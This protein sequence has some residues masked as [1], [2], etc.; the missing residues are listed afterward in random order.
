MAVPDVLIGLTVSHYRI[1]ERLASGG[2]GVVYKAQDTRLDRT[3][4]LKFLPEH[5][6]HDA[7]ALERFRREAKAASALNHPNICTV[8]DIGEAQIQGHGEARQFMAMEFLDGETLKHR[9]AG[10]PLPLELL[11][12]LGIEMADALDAAHS[13]GIIHRDIKPANIFVTNREHAKIL[14]FGL[15][16]LVPSGVERSVSA[17]PTATQ[18]EPM[19]QLGA[20]MGT[21]TYMSP[22]QVRGEE[23]DARTDLFSFGAVL[24]EMA[25]GT[26]AF[27]G[28]TS[29]VIANAIL[30]RVPMPPVQLNPEVPAK[31]EEVIT[32]ALEKDLKLR[33]QH[34]ADVRADLERLKRN[35]E[36]GRAVLGRKAARKPAWPRALSPRSIWVASL[37][38]AL[39]VA[40]VAVLLVKNRHP[41]EAGKAPGGA[42][43]IR[44]MAVLP[45]A[46]LS[47]DTSQDFFAD[48]ITAELINE[49]GTI[50]QLR[51]VS[52][53]S[54]MGY[55]GT[56]TP[57]TQ[58]AR[59]LNVDAILEGSVARSGNHVRIGVGLYDGASE[60]EVWSRTFER[61]MNDVLALED[62]V[63]HA[64]AVQIRLKIASS[65]GARPKVD[66]EA[67]DLYLKGRYAL[68]QGSEDD[69][70]LALVYFHKGIEKDPQYA[71]LY[72]EL[73]NAYALRSFYTDTRPSD[74]FPEAK[75]AAT[76]AL[77]LDPGLAEGHA[78]LA[79]ILNYYDWDRSGAEQEFERALDLNAN[80]AA[81]HQMYARFLASMG[82]LDEA[83]AEMDRARELDPLSLIIQSNAG[84]IA[85]FARQYDDALQQLQKV[86]E[87]DP[88]F[89]VPYWGM[90]LC[91]EQ[92]TKYP[93]AIAQ[94]E[95]GIEL[96]GRGANGIASLAHAYGLAGHEAPARRILAELED[97]S[98]KTYVSSYQFAVI[99]LGLG[100]NQRAMDALENAYRERSTLLG[101]VKMDPRFD[102]L[103]SDP[104]FQSLLSRIHLAK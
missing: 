92:Q 4:A 30:E 27:Q 40:A 34:A 77:Q 23:L 58:I 104:R 19:T 65:L 78:S 55:K 99:Y 20:T 82:R 8:Y 5:L 103:R 91:Y 24:Y 35:F 2:M 69:L 44:S 18:L 52:R 67:Y 95:K 10:K 85:Y 79:Y 89:P 32:K 17:M 51:V 61:D 33:Y 22:E 54:V 60:R 14:D 37:A 7:Q 3:V 101:Y 94:F 45:L 12:Q 53:T 15:V 84:L 75:D 57:L 42:A 43:E 47:G 86:H 31:L 81:T 41:G 28:Q 13:K 39:V 72:T 25:T 68:D 50:A 64:I 102:P 21:L 36:S 48:G 73:A 46:N 97:R 11:L 26:M 80:D 6:A 96:S 38:L 9:I 16:K 90:G 29:G 56:H 83:R 59:D 93:E 76:K 1:V 98:R 70:K 62:E 49:I 100:Q 88:K 87:L 66:P 71:P 63:A 74:A